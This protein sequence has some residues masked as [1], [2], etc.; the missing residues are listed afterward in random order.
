MRD[1]VVVFGCV[2]GPA[3]RNQVR[4]VVE[5]L[6]VGSRVLEAHVRG[7][8]DRG[9]VVDLKALHGKETKAINT[10]PPIFG[11]RRRFAALIG[12]QSLKGI[13]KSWSRISRKMLTISYCTSF[14]R[15]ADIVR[16]FCEGGCAGSCAISTGGGRTR[17]GIFH[18]D[19][20]RRWYGAGTAHVETVAADG[21]GALNET[22]EIGVE[23]ALDS[24]D[25]LRRILDLVDEPM[26]VLLC[27]RQHL[28][29]RNLYR[30]DPIIHVSS[31][32]LLSFGAISLL[33][34]QNQV[35]TDHG[36]PPEHHLPLFSGSPQRAGIWL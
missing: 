25:Q 29:R 6:D 23:Q 18:L 20:A 17:F 34:G 33:A 1:G 24:G 35:S 36:E 26:A 15:P 3:D 16:D 4:R 12:L 32:Q 28:E 14:L 5:G 10:H 13:V 19:V 21:S 7:S 8:I 27:P 30:S 31:G 2:A 22:L 9:Y 11:S